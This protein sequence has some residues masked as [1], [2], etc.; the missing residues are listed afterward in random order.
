MIHIN[1]IPVGFP[2]KQANGISIRIMPFQTNALSCSTY[3]Q[4]I[5]EIEVVNSDEEISKISEVLAEGNSNITEE[6]FALWGSDNTYIE[7]I[8][9]TNLGLERA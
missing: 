8:V 5:N 7:D 3:Y 4:L 9:L 1:P 6:Q 2:S